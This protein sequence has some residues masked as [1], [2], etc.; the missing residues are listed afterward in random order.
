MR[1]VLVTS[2]AAVSS[3]VAVAG[4]G[5]KAGYIDCAGDKHG[6]VAMYSNPCDDE[7]VANL[8]CGEKVEVIAIEGSRSKVVAGGRKG[9]VNGLAISAKKGRFSPPEAPVAPTPACDELQLQIDTSHPR[10]IF[11]PDPEYTEEARR[12]KIQ[13]KV[14]LKVTVGTDGTAHD[15]TVVK[16]LGHGLDENAVQTVRTWKW[17]PA[18]ELGK[19]KA[20][21]ITVEV[22]FQISQ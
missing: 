18:L 6:F 15:I 20:S 8:R 19:P 1:W 13:G 17:Q 5:R 7:T 2:L 10:A 3:A 21:E 12:A 14:I 9:Y 16:G 4:Q 11:A 22:T